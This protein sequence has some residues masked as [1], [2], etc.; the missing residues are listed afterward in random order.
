MYFIV[1][2]RDVFINVTAL[3]RECILICKVAK[4]TKLC[5]S[6]HKFFHL[7]I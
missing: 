4:R 3:F 2:R 6:I 1:S 7:F 5:I